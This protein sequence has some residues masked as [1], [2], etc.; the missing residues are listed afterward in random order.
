MRLLKDRQRRAAYDWDDDITGYSAPFPEFATIRECAA[1]ARPIWLVERGRYGYA[2]VP[3]PLIVRGKDRHESKTSLD[4]RTISV[5]HQNS[6]ILMHEMA[7]ALILSRESHG[8]DWVGCFMGLLCRHAGYSLNWLIK[9]ARQ[10]GLRYSMCKVGPRPASPL[11]EQAASILGR[12]R[13]L[14]AIDL[15]ELTNMNV[16]QAEQALFELVMAKRVA[17]WEDPDSGEDRF[18]IVMYHH[19]CLKEVA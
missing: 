1:W 11:I 13:S 5:A 2:G 7:H 6:Y 16:F 18:E 12:K 17:R 8:P 14:T 4:G 3:M 19:E 15:V 9:A 10:H